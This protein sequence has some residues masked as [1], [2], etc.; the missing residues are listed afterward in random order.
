MRLK[1]WNRRTRQ[2]RKQNSKIIKTSLM[3]AIMAIGLLTPTTMSAYASVKGAVGST[4]VVDGSISI[5]SDV[6]LSLIHI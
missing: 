3:S 5:S 1:I 4:V 6:L 2:S